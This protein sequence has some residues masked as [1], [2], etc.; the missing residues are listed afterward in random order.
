MKQNFIRHKINEQITVPELRVIDEHG[1]NLGVLKR[2]QALALAQERGLDLVEITT[3]V[4]PPVAR[5]I[6][7]DKFRYEEEKKEKKQRLA[8]KNRELK[9]V[10]ITPRI[11][12]NDLKL[13][14]NQVEK[15]L[16][17]GHEVK[18]QLF[19]RGREKSNKERAYQKLNE[20]L[21]AI[22]IPYHLTASIRPGGR[23]FTVQ[24][25]KK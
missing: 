15:F 20:F 4:T 7:F 25:L 18:I 21:A 3:S 22:K 5:I 1:K 23:G 2:D 13:K 9:T 10:Q 17:Q 8:Q 11:A 16:N 14:M 12:A 24:I 19:L 6:N